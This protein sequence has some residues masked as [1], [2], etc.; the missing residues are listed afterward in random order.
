MGVIRYLATTQNPKCFTIM[1]FLI[2]IYF[3]LDY[4]VEPIT[5]KELLL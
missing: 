3:A 1:L 2:Y 5:Y 4:S